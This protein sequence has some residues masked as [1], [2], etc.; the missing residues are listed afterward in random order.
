MLG[1]FA[2]QYFSMEKFALVN[3]SY[4][5]ETRFLGQKVCLLKCVM[6]EHVSSLIHFVSLVTFYTS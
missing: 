5:Q 3:G 6:C 4:A 2:V 1:Q